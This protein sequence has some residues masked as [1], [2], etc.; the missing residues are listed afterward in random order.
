VSRFSEF[1][2]TEGVREEIVLGA[3]VG[4]MALHG[5]LEY[6]TSRLAKSIAQQS[7]ASLYAVVQASDLAWHLP[8]TH[9]DPTV[10]S[11]LGRFLAHVRTVF[12]FHGYHR[13][14]LPDVVL[15]GGNNR[16]LARTLHLALSDEGIPAVSDLRSIPKALRGQHVRNPVNGPAEGGV[17]LELPRSMR[18]PVPM[19]GI[20]AAVTSVLVGMV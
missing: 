10:S 14:E 18:Q 16:S 8:S 5:G 20:V 1:L 9:Y 11:K 4:V 19:P 7:A 17:Q 15:L 3:G 6:G 2:A 12:S 13:P